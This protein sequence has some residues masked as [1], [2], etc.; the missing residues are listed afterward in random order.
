MTYPL[1]ET[2]DQFL[3]RL[4]A[5]REQFAA[6]LKHF[7]TTPERFISLKSRTLIHLAMSIPPT[8]A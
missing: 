2:G 4:A 8:H 5:Q 6:E 3:A 7:I 1:Y